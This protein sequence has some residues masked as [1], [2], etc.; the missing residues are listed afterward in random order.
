MTKTEI[1]K[2]IVEICRTDASFC[3][4]LKGGDP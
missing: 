4:D 2:T 3:R 1:A